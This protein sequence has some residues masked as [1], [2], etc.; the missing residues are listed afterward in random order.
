MELSR[1]LLAR[2][3]QYSSSF[4]LLF[5][6]FTLSSSS[7][8]PSLLV[9]QLR[10]L[11]PPI[12]NLHNMANSSLNVIHWNCRGARN[13]IPDI[14]NISNN[15]HVLCLQETLITLPSQINI[16]CFKHV[17][18]VSDSPS[19]RGLSTFIRNDYNFSILDCKDFAHPSVEIQEI[20]L[21]C[22]LSEPLY[23]FNIY[24]HPGTNT[25]FSFY[26][27]LL[28]FSSA[29]KYILFL[30]DFNAHHTD[31]YDS[32]TDSQGEAISRACEAF[33]LIILND[34]F[35]TFLSSPNFS[36]SVIDLSI[37]SRP[38]VRLTDTE[39]TQDLHNSD[40]FPIRITVRNTHSP[41]Y[42]FSYK[43]RLSADQFSLLQA[44]LLLNASKFVEELSPQLALSPTQKYERFCALLK[45]NISSVLDTANFSPL[46]RKNNKHANARS[47][48]E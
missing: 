1:T 33:G 37:A 8:T 20:I 46:Q 2:P 30:G 40:H 9:A 45:E 39:T 29:N 47:L 11:I 23:I 41:Y 48:M 22:S 31:W 35:P 32:K 7:T 27:K 44:R 21:H 3:L 24:R 42:R 15:I 19:I 26:S 13:K 38:L 28:G 18:L 16:S 10:G 34:G 4:S 36:S 14:Q 5:L 12:I 6:I 17:G 25:P 43:L